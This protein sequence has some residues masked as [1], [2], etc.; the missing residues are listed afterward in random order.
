MIGVYR[1]FEG[2]MRLLGHVLRRL[3]VLALPPVAV[4]QELGGW[5]S[6][7]MVRRYAHLSPAHLAE[8]VNRLRDVRPTLNEKAGEMPALSA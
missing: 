4:L 6:S 8:W 2:C 1:E 7:E 5:A 3:P